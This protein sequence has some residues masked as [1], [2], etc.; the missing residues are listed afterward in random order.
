[1]VK[2]KIMLKGLNKIVVNKNKDQLANISKF[3]ERF[4][5]ICCVVNSLIILQLPFMCLG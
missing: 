3:N 4:L 1:M 2:Q 5:F